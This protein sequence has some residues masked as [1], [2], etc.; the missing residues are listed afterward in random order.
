MDLSLAQESVTHE[1]ERNAILLGNLLSKQNA[2]IKP[3]SITSLKDVEF[4]VFSQFGEDGIIQY[5]IGKID[6][7][8]PIFVEFGVENYK[9]SNT[10]F[11]LMANNWNGMV[12]DSSEYNVNSI[13][14]TAY[15]WMHSIC[16]QEHLL[17]VKI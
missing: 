14:S 3:S 7:P 6:I 13:Q 8:N 12:I 16:A 2:S 4:R 5:L 11:L 9:E 1:I 10:R 15:Y 17:Q